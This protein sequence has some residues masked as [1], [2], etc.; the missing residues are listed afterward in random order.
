MR[1]KPMKSFG[2]LILMTLICI[3]IFWIFTALRPAQ[4]GYSGA[5][6]WEAN[7]RVCQIIKVFRANDENVWPSGENGT[8]VAINFDEIADLEKAIHNLKIC[9]KFWTCAAQRDGYQPPPK[10]VRR[11]KHCYESMWNGWKD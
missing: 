7:G 3:V 6:N 9:N 8:S 2:N 10:G 11:P 5:H 1:S 4:A